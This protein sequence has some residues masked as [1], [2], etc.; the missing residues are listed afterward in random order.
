[1][2]NQNSHQTAPKRAKAKVEFRIHII[3]YI[4]INTIL[5]VINLT[6]TPEYIWFK[7][8]LLGWGI[9]I[10]LHALNVYHSENTRNKND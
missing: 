7:W 1:M 9:G 6:L 8:P 3:N 4:V 10:I 5:A 2:N